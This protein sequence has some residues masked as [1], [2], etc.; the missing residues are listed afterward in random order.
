MLPDVSDIFLRSYVTPV[1]MT[2]MKSDL[3]VQVMSHG[4][5]RSVVNGTVQD[6]KIQRPT[7][8]KKARRDWA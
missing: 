2:D 7:V 1:L 3:S 4:S 5:L 6:F 8:D